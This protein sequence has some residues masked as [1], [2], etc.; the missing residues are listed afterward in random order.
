MS[1][2][3][4]LINIDHQILLLINSNFTPFF[5]D[6]MWI[7]SKKFVW[8]PLYL[9]LTVLLFNKLGVRKAVLSL[10]LTGLLILTVDQLCASFIRPLFCR[11]RPSS[12]DNPVS[13]LLHFVNDYRGGSYGFPSCHA[14]NTFALVTFLSF[15]FR[16]RWIVLS[17]LVWSLLVSY[18]RIYLGVHYPLD[19]LM[20]FLI[21][22][23]CARLYYSLYLF[24][25]RYRFPS[26]FK[27]IFRIS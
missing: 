21:G 26:F 2:F 15:L 22:Y 5:D 20:G 4:H 18:S 7:I 27:G 3:D 25:N 23:L 12:P 24:L 1:F 13:E 6:V 10:L 19:I 11:L 14:A 17:L 16:Q 9:L 8:I